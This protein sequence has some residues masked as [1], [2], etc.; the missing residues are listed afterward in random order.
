MRLWEGS[1]LSSPETT[2]STPRGP[3]VPTRVVTVCLRETTVYSQWY[4][5]VTPSR[6]K[7]GSEGPGGVT[8]ILHLQYSHRVKTSIVGPQR[9]GESIIQHSAPTSV[10]EEEEQGTV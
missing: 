7:V 9:G 6:Q 5:G 4:V 2:S 10:L 1:T 3:C 8:E